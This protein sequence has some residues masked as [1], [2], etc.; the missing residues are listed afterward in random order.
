MLFIF[1]ALFW[2]Y[3]VLPIEGNYHPIIIPGKAE[4]FS[5]DG[6][7]SIGYY[8]DYPIPSDTI[9]L[10][11][12]ICNIDR[13]VCTKC[14]NCTL[15]GYFFNEENRKQ[16]LFE[17]RSLKNEYNVRFSYIGQPTEITMRYGDEPR[18]YLFRIP[19]PSI[20]QA[21]V[22]ALNENPIL[23]SIQLILSFSPVVGIGAVIIKRRK[24]IECLRKRKPKKLDYA[25]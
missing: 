9:T 10:T 7:F 8:P 22:L 16:Y 2:F 25:S 4:I 23:G 15:S 5:I 11:V 18:E 1:G 14:E 21:I 6:K 3:Q 24:I 13:S 17:N 20:Y 19:K 12:D